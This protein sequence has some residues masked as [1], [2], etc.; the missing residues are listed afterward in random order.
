[1][2][3]GFVVPMQMD[4]AAFRLTVGFD[5]TVI[6]CAE[7]L[8]EQELPPT[9]AVRLRL[10]T[11]GLVNCKAGFIET[12]PVPP[13]YEKAETFGVHPLLLL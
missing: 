2:A 13:V 6:V 11:P 5:L 1:M 7:L 12:L 9:E 10:Y 4:E 8:A 3:V